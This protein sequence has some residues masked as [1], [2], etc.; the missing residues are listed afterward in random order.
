M[1]PLHGPRPRREEPVSTGGRL[2]GR[3]GRTQAVHSVARSPEPGRRPAA[4]D[5]SSPP[6]PSS[7][8][9]TRGAPPASSCFPSALPGRKSRGPHHPDRMQAGGP[10]SLV[11]Q[12]RQ[13]TE[14]LGEH[15]LL[16][17]SLTRAKHALRLKNFLFFLKVMG[18]TVFDFSFRSEG[19]TL[20][21]VG[22]TKGFLDRAFLFSSS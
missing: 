11:G 17:V 7:A 16:R 13:A 9:R 20:F 18:R 15:T 21:V 10:R 8:G 1:D 2:R 4:S 3:G 19:L 6:N 14:G 22:S 5:G 12:P